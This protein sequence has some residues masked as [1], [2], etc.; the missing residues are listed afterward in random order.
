MHPSRRRFMQ[1]SAMGTAAAA[2][3]RQ[4]QGEPTSISLQS[5]FETSQR[6]RRVLKRLSPRSLRALRFAVDEAS[7]SRCSHVDTECLLIG[8]SAEA[9]YSGA[10]WL[11][12]LGLTLDDVAAIVKRLAGTKASTS[13]VSSGRLPITSQTQQI[14]VDGIAHADHM[15]YLKAQPEHLLLGMINHPDSTAMQALRQMWIDVASIEDEAIASLPTWSSVHHRF[16]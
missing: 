12:G 11:D 9:E 6:Q 2:F 4:S 5:E 1:V 16:D 8:L 3:A 10:S 7:E 13:Q 15:G 14:L